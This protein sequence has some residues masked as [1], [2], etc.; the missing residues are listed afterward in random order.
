MEVVRDDI[1][2]ELVTAKVRF[3]SSIRRNGQTRARIDHRGIL[4]SLPSGQ[5]L[6]IAMSTQSERVAS[7]YER[8]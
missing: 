1:V 4:A 8:S 6:L 7:A 5:G 3:Y 2:D